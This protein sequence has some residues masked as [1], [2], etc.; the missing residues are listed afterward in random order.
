MVPRIPSGAYKAVT[1]SRSVNKAGYIERQKRRTRMSRRG[2]TDLEMNALLIALLFIGLGYI[3]TRNVTGSAL[4]YGILVGACLIVFLASQTDRLKDWCR[5][6]YC[7]DDIPI[8]HERVYRRVEALLRAL[9]SESGKTRAEAR[10]VLVATSDYQRI[11]ACDPENITG[12][13][14]I[15]RSS[16]RGYGDALTLGEIVDT[17]RQQQFDF[18]AAKSLAQN[19]K[20]AAQ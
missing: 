2:T 10:G 20:L 11:A 16:A 5:V 19:S 14:S 18:V 13:H 6:T 15:L 17:C 12:I 4:Y 8:E 9:L 3:P 1:A 7:Q